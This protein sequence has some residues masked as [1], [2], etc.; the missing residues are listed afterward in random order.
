MDLYIEY[1]LFD[2]LE[3]YYLVITTQLT[4]SNILLGDESNDF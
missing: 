4:N 1:N 2:L 3:Y